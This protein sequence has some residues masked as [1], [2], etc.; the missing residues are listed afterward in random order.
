MLSFVTALFFLSCRLSPLWNWSQEPAPC[1]LLLSF[2]LYLLW[3]RYSR[4]NLKLERRLYGGGSW[5]PL[6]KAT[7]LDRLCGGWPGP[8]MYSRVFFLAYRRLVAPKPRSV[9]SVY[10][11]GPRQHQPSCCARS[12]GSYHVLDTCADQG[13]CI[14]TSNITSA[15]P[16]LDLPLSALP[17]V[18]AL[19]MQESDCKLFEYAAGE[20]DDMAQQLQVVAAGQRDALGR[21]QDLSDGEHI[22]DDVVSGLAV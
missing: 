5:D 16:V 14:A 3:A 6:H 19:S 9:W 13:S 4:Y 15:C 7:A 2:R 20:A 17:C 18:S 21:A 1:S 11:C 12:P 22:S 10:L 8:H